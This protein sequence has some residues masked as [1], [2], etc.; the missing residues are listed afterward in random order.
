[1]NSAYDNTVQDQ[2]FEELQAQVDIDGTLTQYPVKAVLDSWTLQSG[3][4]IV[5]LSWIGGS[6][7]LI[8]QVK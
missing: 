3:F 4:P 1:M 7:V 8:S 6:A 2:L 5:T